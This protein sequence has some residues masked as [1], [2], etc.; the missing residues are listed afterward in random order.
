M[1]LAVDLFC[2]AGGASVGL[3]RAGFD[4]VGVDIAAQP[5]YP[6][7]FVLGDALDFRIPSAACLVWASPPCQLY[8]C[9]NAYNR[10]NYPDLV[11]VVREKLQ[12]WGGSYVIENVPTAPLLAP[13]I[14]CGTMFG[15]PVYRHRGFETNFRVQPLLHPQHVHK[16]ARNG[17]L[18]SPSQPFMTITGGRHSA[19]WLMAARDAMGV[20]WMR[21]IVEVCESIP[22][23]YA[24]YVGEQVP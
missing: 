2:G 1:R 13:R 4:V 20:G 11:G 21:T 10:K 18:P 24:Q 14:L 17:Y 12:R 23:A 8:S 9:L 6:F 7:E 22:P 19:R 5:N 15:L 16:C 3:S